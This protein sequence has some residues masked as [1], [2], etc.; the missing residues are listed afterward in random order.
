MFLILA[1]FLMDAGRLR[2]SLVYCLFTSLIGVQLIWEW[3]GIVVCGTIVPFLILSF[4]YLAA[5]PLW[6][7]SAVIA[8]CVGIGYA[9][10]QLI[11]KVT[12]VWIIV[13]RTYIYSFLGF[14]LLTYFV[15]GFYLRVSVWVLGTTLGESIYAITIWRYGW[16]EPIGDLAFMDVLLF[17]MM[18]MWVTSG[19][20]A[21]VSML[22]QLVSVKT[23]R[24]VGIKP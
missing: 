18:C 17:G 8:W 19:F 11:E 12:P 4:R 24:K 6:K 3:D 5:H 20:V 9:G 13:D 10:L 7:S 1:L 23:R 14:V 15:R 22:E 21:I 16:S 2:L